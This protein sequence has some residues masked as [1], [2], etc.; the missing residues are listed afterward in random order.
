MNE[1]EE[2]QVER[3]L[4]LRDPP[5]GAQPGPEQRP[6]A[7]DRVDMD[8]AEAIAVLVTGELA[9]RMADGAMGV[10]PFGQSS[11]DVVLVG[12][13]LRPRGNR[14]LDQGTDRGLF[15]VPEHPDH[16]LPAAPDHAE[17]GRLLLG[18]RPATTLP[19]QLPAAAGAA[20]FFHLLGMTLMSCS[21]IGF[22]T[23]H[24]TAERDL[25]LPD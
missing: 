22:V 13:D 11:V 15:D 23:F 19:F 20:S 6:E 16:D 24:L 2:T 3:Q 8:F 17:D 4:L 5:M 18:Q 10:A 7:F 9:R 12:V 21:R 25:R 1:L 14:V